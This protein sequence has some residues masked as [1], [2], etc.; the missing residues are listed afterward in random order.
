MKGENQSTPLFS[1]Q[2][3]TT[4]DYRE[5]AFKKAAGVRYGAGQSRSA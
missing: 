4:A 3:F 1:G 2:K 5:Q